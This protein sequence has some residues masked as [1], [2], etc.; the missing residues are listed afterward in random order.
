VRHDP[1]YLE[2]LSREIDRLALE[3]PRILRYPDRCTQLSDL[4]DYFLYLT[5]DAL[6]D[7]DLAR[8]LVATFQMLEGRSRTHAKFF[9]ALG[10]LLSV[11]NE[12]RGVP[13]E[14]ISRRAFEH[15]WERT[16]LELGL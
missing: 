6:D 9:F 16:R 15:S 1:T 14:R 13:G 10:Q 4:R 3:G 5:L 11:R 2:R 7:E 8:E 12:I